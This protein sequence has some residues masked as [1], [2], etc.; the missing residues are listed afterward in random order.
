M[1]NKEREGMREREREKERMKEEKE[2]KGKK[3]R[4]IERAVKERTP[5]FLLTMMKNRCFL[6]SA[7]SEDIPRI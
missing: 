4:N 5:F 3:Q 6:H 1:K 7:Q 2:G